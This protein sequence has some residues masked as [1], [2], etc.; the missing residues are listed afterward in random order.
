MLDKISPALCESMV[1]I[2]SSLGFSMKMFL[3]THFSQ[4]CL[5]NDVII[6]YT[7]GLQQ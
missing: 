6:H 4:T 2:P 5:P 3:V 1:A 7:V